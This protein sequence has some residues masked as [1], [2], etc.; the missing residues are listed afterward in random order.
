VPCGLARNG[1]PIGVQI[2]GPLAG[3][4]TVLRAARTQRADATDAAGARYLSI[5]EVNK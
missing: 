4:Q 1:L 2:V 3:D 5:C